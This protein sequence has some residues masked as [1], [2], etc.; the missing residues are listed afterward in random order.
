MYEEEAFE[1]LHQQFEPMIFHVMNKLKIYKTKWISI[2]L[3]VLLY[4]KHP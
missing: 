4:G 2:K 3:A 1:M